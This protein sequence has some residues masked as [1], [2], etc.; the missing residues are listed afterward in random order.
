MLRVNAPFILSLKP[1][2]IQGYYFNLQASKP[3]QH[4]CQLVI[5]STVDMEEGRNNKS[6]WVMT[7]ESLVTTLWIT[8]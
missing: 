8:I 6:G 7:V 4:L 3:A 5:Y 2:E 1:L